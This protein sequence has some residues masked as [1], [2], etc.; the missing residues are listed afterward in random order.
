MPKKSRFENMQCAVAQAMDQIGDEWSILVIRD[1]F[2]G[3]RR[4]SDFQKSTLIARNVLTDRLTKLVENGVFERVDVGTRGTR[5]EYQLTEKGKDLFILLTALRD[6]GD[7]WIFGEGNEPLKVIDRKTRR[8]ISKL[9]VTDADGNE[10]Q[11]GDVTVDPIPFFA[12]SRK[13]QAAE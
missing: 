11:T 3:A 2:F 12:K 1:A 4:F 7:K 6:W 8:P 9:V 13:K 5:Y 10:V